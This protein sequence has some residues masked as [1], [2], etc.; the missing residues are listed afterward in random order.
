MSTC[1]QGRM[2][3]RGPLAGPRRLRHDT[4]VMPD[5]TPYGLA[6][7]VAIMLAK[8]LGVPVPIP[9][10]LLM[11]A[12]GVQAAVGAYPLPE[13]ALGILVAVAV[14]ISVQFLVIRRVGRSPVYRLAP[15]VILRP[16]RLDAVAQKLRD[17]GHLRRAQRAG[18]ARGR[19]LVST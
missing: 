16:E 17:S 11:I 9:S 3:H 7:I 12:A 19:S 5:V 14:G 6:A 13:L 8:E 10:D 2:A 15:R 1:H 4:G 18:R